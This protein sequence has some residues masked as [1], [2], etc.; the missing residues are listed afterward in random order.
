MIS[1][2]NV[3]TVAN[4]CDCLRAVAIWGQETK[5]TL[6][7]EETLRVD[8]CKHISFRSQVQTKSDLPLSQPCRPSNSKKVVSNR[9]CR[10]V[11]ALTCAA[12]QGSEVS[13]YGLFICHLPGVLVT[14]QTAR[15]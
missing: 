13:T 8:F 6:A 3:T 7:S 11:N 4:E 1:I 2:C 15:L 12:S 9:V 5:H 10:L 14:L